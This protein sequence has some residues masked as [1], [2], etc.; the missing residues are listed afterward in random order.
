MHL[1]KLKMEKDFYKKLYRKYQLKDAPNAIG[2][3]GA[4]EFVVTDRTTPTDFQDSNR[5]QTRAKAEK[6]P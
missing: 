2:L 1:T 4:E 5:E 3:N 6:Y